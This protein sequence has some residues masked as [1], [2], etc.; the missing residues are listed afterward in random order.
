MTSENTD[1]PAESSASSQES[2]S[3]QEHA[4]RLSRRNLLIAGAT[5]AASPAFAPGSVTPAQAQA[6]ATPP[7]RF[8]YPSNREA[9]S[10]ARA[11]ALESLLIEK[12][13]I[14]GKSVDN[15]LSF[16]ETQMGPFNGAKV[17]ARAWVDPAF[18]QRLGEDTPGAIAT[19]D[20]PKGMVDAEFDMIWRQVE[21][22]LKREGATADTCRSRYCSR[23]ATTGSTAAALR[24]GSTEARRA[25]APRSA[26]TESATRGSRGRTL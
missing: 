21:A 13:V 17:V 20:L 12:G 18:K 7:Q 16:F 14:T 8:Q 3:A 23:S 1:R 19:L 4:L 6:P 2:A 25:T 15:V 11:K 24:A 5:A 10:A 26:D 9:L 22:E